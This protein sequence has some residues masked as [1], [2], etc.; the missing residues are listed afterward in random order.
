M[1]R[2]EA[3]RG[4]HWCACCS[5]TVLL[6]RRNASPYKTKFDLDRRDRTSKSGIVL[7]IFFHEQWLA[8]FDSRKEGRADSWLGKW[9]DSDNCLIVPLE[10]TV[11]GKN[12]IE[13]A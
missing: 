6:L 13:D 4:G 1:Y 10:E 12:E 8:L 11:E 5:T 7:F 2:K 9:V 3:N